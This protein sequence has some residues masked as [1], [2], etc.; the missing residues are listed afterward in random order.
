MKGMKGMKAMKAMKG[1]ICASLL[2][3][4]AHA[5]SDPGLGVLL[6]TPQEREYLESLRGKPPVTAI[7]ELSHNT[8]PLPTKVKEATP[9][10]LPEVV[11]LRGVVRRSGGAEVAWINQSHTLVSRQT[12]DGVRLDTLLP[13]GAG[14]VLELVTSGEKIML[15]SGQTHDLARQQTY[16]VY[17]LPQ[18][19]FPSPE[20]ADSR[21][22]DESPLS[23]RSW[24]AQPLGQTDE[25]LQE[26]DQM[27]PIFPSGH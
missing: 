23:P 7:D 17:M 3:A 27:P 24:I 12:P 21:K 10:A 6:T 4:P 25:S 11:R 16:E 8:T 13:N 18:G 1:M 22:R 19:E 5:G 14:A 26:F 9:A 2:L 20:P 15:R